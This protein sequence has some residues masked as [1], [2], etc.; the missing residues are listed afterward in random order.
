MQAIV[1]NHLK[2]FRKSPKTV[3]RIPDVTTLLGEFA[4]YSHG[5][6]ILCTNERSLFVALSESSDNQVHVF[7]TLTKDKKKFSLSSLK[8]R[9]EDK[10]G[11]Y[12][13]GVFFMLAEKGFE[14]KTF[15]ITIDGPALKNG[16]SNIAALISIGVCCALKEALG[17]SIE[18]KEMA[19]LC[20]QYWLQ[21]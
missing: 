21:H 14:L 13:K 8:F 9:K 4:Y 17:L 20:H 5:N 2:E 18:E 19:L 15:D 12:I 16:N 1:D 6:A 3:V 11:N 10:W 7:N